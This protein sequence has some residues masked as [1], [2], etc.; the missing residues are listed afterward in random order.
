MCGRLTITLFHPSTGQVRVKRVTSCPNIVLHARLE[1]ALLT[2]LA[3]LPPAQLDETDNWRH[4][5]AGKRV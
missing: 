4:G 1:A 5:S 2:I 3:A